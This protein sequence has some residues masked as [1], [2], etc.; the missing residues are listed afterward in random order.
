MEE[1]IKKYWDEVANSKEFTTPFKKEEFLNLVSMESK[2]LDVGCGYGRTLNELYQLGYKDLIGLDFST[3][4]IEEGKN[5]F[6]PFGLD[7]YGC[8]NYP[9]RGQ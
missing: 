5:D 4:M 8:R 2:I 1:W 3:G 6:S 7:A 9:L